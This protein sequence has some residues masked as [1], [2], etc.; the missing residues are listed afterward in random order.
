MVPGSVVQRL[1]FTCLAWIEHQP[2]GL[3]CLMLTLAYALCVVFMIPGTPFNLGSGYLFG[4]WLGVPVALLGGTVGAFFAFLLGRF[5]VRE[6]AEHKMKSS[7]KFRV[8]DRAIK[9]NGMNLVFLMRLSPILPFPLL[10]YVFGA[11]QVHWL[12]YLVGTCLGLTPATIMESM[13]GREMKSLTAAFDGETTSYSWVVVV[14]VSTVITLLFVSYITHRALKRTMQEDL[15]PE[16][17]PPP[18]PPLSPLKRSNTDKH[19]A[20][21][22]VSTSVVS[23]T[24]HSPNGSGA[25][26]DKSSSVSS[27]SS[28]SHHHKKALFPAVSDI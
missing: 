10:S 28:G 7:K 27:S 8:I 3:G 26:G 14:I 2:T 4:I 5:L 21:T 25:L 9:N 11:T 1:L 13:I 20:L 15:A 16:D 12:E 18:S 17:T 24:G 19:H 23:A 6:W 22:S